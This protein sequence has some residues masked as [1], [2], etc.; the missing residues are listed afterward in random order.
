VALLGALD[1][2]NIGLAT[3]MPAV[4]FVMVLYY[5]VWKFVVGFLN[6]EVGIG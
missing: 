3:V 1:V 4:P 5:L 2:V 6:R